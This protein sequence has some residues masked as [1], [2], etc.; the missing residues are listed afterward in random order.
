MSDLSREIHETDKNE[1]Q[2]NLYRKKILITCAFTVTFINTGL[3][4]CVNNTTLPDWV[5][6][7]GTDI[8]GYGRMMLVAMIFTTL[9]NDILKY[10]LNVLFKMIK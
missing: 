8:E 6:R 1:Y 3:A 2:S 5:S 7:I 10:H 9:G 4:F